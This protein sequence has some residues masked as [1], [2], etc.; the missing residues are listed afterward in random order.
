MQQNYNLVNHTANMFAT[1]K[2]KSVFRQRMP[3]TNWGSCEDCTLGKPRSPVG[4]DDR[5]LR[6]TFSPRPELERLLW[7]VESSVRVGSIPIHT[8]LVPHM[9]A[10]CDHRLAPQ[11]SECRHSRNRWLPRRSNHHL[12]VC[13]TWHTAC[14]SVGWRLLDVLDEECKFFPTFR[15]NLNTR[16][17]IFYCNC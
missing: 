13:E 1:S 7:A 14:S 17:S 3:I 11:T 16:L 5:V 6:C 2:S 4:S 12:R 9:S 8:E 10:W 15:R